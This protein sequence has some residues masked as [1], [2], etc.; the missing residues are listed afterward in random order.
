[1]ATVIVTHENFLKEFLDY[2]CAI[3]ACV[4]AWT[5]GSLKKKKIQ[6]V[7]SQQLLFWNDN[8]TVKRATGLLRN[9]ASWNRQLLFITS[10]GTWIK[11][12]LE[13]LWLMSIIL[14]LRK[15]SSDKK[16]LLSLSSF[17]PYFVVNEV[18][19][20]ALHLVDLLL[21]Y[22]LSSSKIQPHPGGNHKELNLSWKKLHTGKS[23]G[24]NTSLAAPKVTAALY[25]RRHSWEVVKES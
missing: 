6:G 15:V 9:V 19:L 25:F 16:G 11:T 20:T 24:T 3:S 4:I 8:V 21:D 7:L 5:T 14:W 12:L 17:I 1:M 22:T 18:Y 2:C 13:T 23:K 10:E